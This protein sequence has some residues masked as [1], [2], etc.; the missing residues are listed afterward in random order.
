MNSAQDDRSP[1]AAWL[2]PDHRLVGLAAPLAALE[3]VVE[4]V[5]RHAKQSGRLGLGVHLSIKHAHG[6]RSQ[7]VTRAGGQERSAPGRLG[8]HT[9][10]ADMWG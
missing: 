3:P 7:F 4:R 1:P 6:H 2:R 10:G 9:E 5:L 8:R